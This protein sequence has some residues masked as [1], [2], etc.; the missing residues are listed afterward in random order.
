MSSSMLVHSQ[1]HGLDLQDTA[2]ADAN[3]IFMTDKKARDEL[4]KKAAGGK[5][6]LNTGQQGIK[7]SGKK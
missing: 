5:G 1:N 2:K 4:A 7:K 3:N 6:P